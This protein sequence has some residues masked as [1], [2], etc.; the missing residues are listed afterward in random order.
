MGKGQ[1]E[2]GRRASKMERNWE[3]VRGIDETFGGRGAEE[4]LSDVTGL[5]KVFALQ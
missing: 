1:R 5:F 3:E 2:E 4:G